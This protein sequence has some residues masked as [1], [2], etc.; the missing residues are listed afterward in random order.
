MT[1]DVFARGMTA[2]SETFREKVTGAR[3]EVYYRALQDLTDEQWD[4][5]VTQAIQTLRFFPKPV[6][7]REVVMGDLDAVA[8][9]AWDEAWD[10]ASS[11]GAYQTPHGL[12]PVTVAVISAM[13]GWAAFCRPE[14]S[15]KWHRAEFVKLWKILAPRRDDLGGKAL[16]GLEDADRAERPEFYEPETHRPR[17]RAVPRLPPRSA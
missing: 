4:A 17:L 14:E 3:S 6:E 12:D 5:A 15:E 1:R 13:G 2:L 7:L 16:V 8:L 11:V 9:A 10:M